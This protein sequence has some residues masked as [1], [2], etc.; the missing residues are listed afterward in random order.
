MQGARATSADA[1]IRDWGSERRASARWLTTGGRGDAQQTV[2][3]RRVPS[4]P[5]PDP[6]DGRGAVPPRRRRRARRRPLR[7]PW[8]RQWRR[9]RLSRRRRRSRRRRWRERAI[10]AVTAVAEAAAIGSG[11][12][13]GGGG[14][15]GYVGNGAHRGGWL[16]RRSR[17]RLSW[18]ARLSGAAV[19]TAGTVMAAHGLSA[20]RLWLR[21][22]LSRI[23]TP[24]YYGAD[25]YPCIRPDG[26]AVPD[27]MATGSMAIPAVTAAMGV[28]LPWLRRRRGWRDRRR[29]RRR[30]DRRRDRRQ[31]RANRYHDGDGAVG[32]IVGGAIG[33]LIGQRDRV[34]LPKRR[35]AIAVRGTDDPAFR[36]PTKSATLGPGG[37]N[38]RETPVPRKPRSRPNSRR[39]WRRSPRRPTPAGPRCNASDDTAPIGL[40][41]LSPDCRY[42]QINQRLTEICGISVEDHLGRHGSRMRAGPGQFSRSHRPHDDGIPTNR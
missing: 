20:L 26:D 32:A 19:A 13:G 24:P 9:W 10:A 31:Q 15:G 40:A 1:T 42:L 17:R 35:R 7:R 11:Y 25:A 2:S 28:L 8:R 23:I 16:S 27:L 39:T 4:S 3:W 6:G 37:A 29:H 34:R 5:D 22:R 38:R 21:L 33:A 30:G 18:R 36:K 41:F 14:R 12:R